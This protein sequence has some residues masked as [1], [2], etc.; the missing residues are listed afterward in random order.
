MLPRSFAVSGLAVASLLLSATTVFAQA[1]D[2]GMPFSEQGTYLYRELGPSYNSY[3]SPAAP[4]MVAP[5]APNSTYQSFYPA[6]LEPQKVFFNVTLPAGARLS[7]QGS[8]TRQTGPRRSFESPSL[9]PGLNYSYL[10]EA[11]W[12]Q[13]DRDMVVT[14]RIPVQP[15]QT[16][17]VTIT[18]DA[19]VNI[20][21]N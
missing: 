4:V 2:Y 12:R 9:Q 1:R 8:Q 10:V 18:P 14:R 15:G 3:Y 13:N 16:I 20:S 17:N 7:F 6:S 5:G 19:A 11:R 21:P